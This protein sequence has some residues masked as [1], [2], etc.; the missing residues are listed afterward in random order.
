MRQVLGNRGRRLTIL[1]VALFATAGGI[2]YATIP[3]SGGVYTACMLKGV[4]T[5]R[6]IDPS[7]SS[8]S[9]LSHCSVFETQVNWN[10]TGPKGDAGVSP[11]VAQLSAGDSNCPAGGAAITDAAGA[12][13]Y[14]CSG[15]NGTDGQSF[16]G[17]FT[18]PNG[19]YSLNV[20]DGGVEIVGP[21]STITV[22]GSSGVTIASN[23]T[24]TVKADHN[25]N[26]QSGDTVTVKSGS[27]LSVQGDGSVT[28]QSA[29]HLALNGGGTVGINEGA[30]CI[31]AARKGDLIEG[32]A[33]GASVFGDILTGSPIV[34]IG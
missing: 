20:T 17:A 12:T 23:G 15:Q 27:T 19:Q 13:A 21:N 9:L 29:G 3:D 31:P 4:G 11:T 32:T 14:V 10:R 18:S 8:G 7:A 5:I 25:V 16:S 24:V 2:A 34:C 28:V 33:T 26:V 1:V 30:T 6:L 22:S